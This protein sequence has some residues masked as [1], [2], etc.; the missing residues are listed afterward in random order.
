MLVR[1][2]E[3]DIEIDTF[4]LVYVQGKL[5]GSEVRGGHLKEMDYDRLKLYYEE[6]D[7]LFFVE[8]DNIEFAYG[9]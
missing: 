2:I 6:I 3:Q 7:G 9:E 5:M 1:I 8:T 4:E